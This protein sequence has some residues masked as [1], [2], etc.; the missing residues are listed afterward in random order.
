VTKRAFKKFKRN[1]RDFYATPH[2]AVI[3]LEPHLPGKIIDFH[4]PCFG[5]G[6]LAGSLQGFGHNCSAATDIRWGE[7]AFDLTKCEGVCFVTNPPWDRKVLHPL[8]TH[9][10]NL[11]PTFLLFDADWMHTKQSRPFMSRCR[12]I[13]SVGRVSWLGNGVSGFDNCAWYEFDKHNTASTTFVG[14]NYEAV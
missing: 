5:D 2:S 14:R 10:S 9:L 12:K 7:D 8:I 6:D 1:P 13:I 3:P 11:A 4:E